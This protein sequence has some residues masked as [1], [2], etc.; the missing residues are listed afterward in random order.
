[1]MERS[2]FPLVWG[3][4]GCSSLLFMSL[5]SNTWLPHSFYIV[6]KNPMEERKKGL[7]KKVT[8]ISKVTDRSHGLYGID[9]HFHVHI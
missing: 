9:F 7:H 2:C 3:M 8:V 5:H 1:M 4:L 6:A